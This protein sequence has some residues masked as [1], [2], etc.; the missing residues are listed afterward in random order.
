[1][2]FLYSSV[3]ILLCHFPSLVLVPGVIEM[4]LSNGGGTAAPRTGMRPKASTE[5]DTN[6]SAIRDALL[7]EPGSVAEL[8]AIGRDGR[9]ASGYFDDP[10]LL[11][12]KA[13]ALDESRDYSG[14]YVTL[15]PVRPALLARRANRIEARLGRKDATTA[16]GDI[17]RRRW[18]PIDIDPVRAS[19]IS[20]TAGEHEDALAVAA[21]TRAFLDGLGW[22]APVVAD[23][24][25]GAHLLYRVD[26]PNDDESTA[27][28]KAVLAALDERFST[29]AAKIDCA[30]FNAGRIWKCY[31]TVGRKGDSTADRPHRRSAVL[32]APGSPAPVSALLL[33]SLAATLT[34]AP[35][36]HEPAPAA[37][38]AGDGTNPGAAAA[39]DEVL[40]RGD[41][42]GFLLE[43]FARDHVGD[44]TLAHCL[45]MSIASRPS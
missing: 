37:G 5:R 36:E 6:F 16:D 14:V 4:N 40:E 27:L 22:P 1:M 2:A 41:P 45:V 3:P 19:G 26:L 42:V 33:G 29:P 15:N 9:V 34:A 11:A 7:L 32:E 10:A 43:A 25:N 24:G 20:A 18:L 38:P 44:E 17:L 13:G 12:E 39:A 23:S 8:R 35:P 30:N 28:V 21:R 31:G